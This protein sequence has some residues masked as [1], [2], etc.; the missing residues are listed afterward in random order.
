MT[1]HSPARADIPL[2]PGLTILSQGKVRDSYLLPDGKILQVATDAI[3]I[4]DFILN[5]LVPMKGIILTAMSV[6]WFKL[7]ESYG[8]KTHLVAFGSEIDRYLPES[9]R[10][11]SD[12]QS[13]SLVVEYLEMADDVEFIIRSYL[14]GSGKEAYDRTG[15]IC[16]HKLPS[17]LQDG[18]ALP[19]LLDTPTTKA[20]AGHD[21]HM[22]AEDVRKKYPDQ[23]YMALRIF[24]IAQ[25]Y[26]ETKGIILADT[27]FEFGSNGTLA[28]EVLTP[29][30]SRFWTLTEWEASRKSDNRK[31]PPANDKQ[32]VRIWG[33]TEDIH[34]RDPKN[35]EDVDHV[36]SLVVPEEV[37]KSTTD[38]YRYI[39]WRLT[40]NTIEQYLRKIMKVT[41]PDRPA[42][43]ILIICGSETDLTTV[44]TACL[45]SDAAKIRIDIMSC[46]RNPLEVMR[47][48]ETEDLLQYDVIIGAGSKA[49]ALPGILDA[50]ISQFERNI[51]VCGVALGEPGSKAL[52]AAQLSIEELPGQPVI[53]NEMTGQSYSGISGFKELLWRINNGELPPLKPR[54]KKPVQIL[55][56]KNYSYLQK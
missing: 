55:A 26:A 56:W 28:D 21:E 40:G 35:I 33:K 7:L 13:R 45:S 54:T 6:F 42:K 30:S 44:K 39:F 27:K 14:T 16:G 10:N 5:A 51:P 38:S 2:L 48:A 8:I 17:G 25:A 3:S 20:T 15:M 49:L 53:I 29:D 43:N 41:V 46:H 24:Q 11:N 37:I 34:M 50:W 52:L 9:L 19:Y 31:A 4:F 12:L 36:H 18:D 1:K 22:S 32:L 47:F 23:T